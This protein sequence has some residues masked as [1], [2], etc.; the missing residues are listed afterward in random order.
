L[1]SF[2]VK[3]SQFRS[4]FVV[5]ILA[6]LLEKKGPLGEITNSLL[7]SCKN[8]HQI[9]HFLFQRKIEALVFYLHS[10]QVNSVACN[11]C[12]LMQIG[13]K[14]FVRLCMQVC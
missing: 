3:L 5:E 14:I 4:F 11:I 6:I 1:W 7:I 10:V 9:F 8:L 12:M 13:I 2:W